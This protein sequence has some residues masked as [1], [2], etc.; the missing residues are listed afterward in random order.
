MKAVNEQLKPEIENPKRAHTS[1]RESEERYCSLVE[2][3]SKSLYLV[4]EE[5]N[6]LFMTKKHRQRLGLVSTRVEGTAYA[7]CHTKQET[8]AFR[9]KVKTVFETGRPL[10]YE[11]QSEQVG[12]YFVRTLSPV[13]DGET[14]KAVSVFSK[15]ITRQKQAEVEI[16]H[17]RFELA[18]LERLAAMGELTASLAHEIN[19]PLTTILS[20][21]QA[22]LRFIHGNPP[23]IDEVHATLQ[24]II[25]ADRRA[26]EI[27][28][29]LRAF[30][31]KGQLKKMPQAVNK[32]INDAIALV[33]GDVLL[34]KVSIEKSL[35]KQ[36]PRVEG[37]RVDLQ[38]VILNLI[39]NASDSMREIN[40]RPRRVV[41]STMRENAS[42][43]KIGI[44]DV[45]KGI[46]PDHL[47]AIF[48]PYFTTKK[49]GMGMGLAIC[50]SIID[51]HGGKIWAENNP[52][53][54]ATFYFTLPITE[55]D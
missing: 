23:D 42:F 51:A 50:R 44:R 33:K 6:Y 36:L 37:D 18:H 11:Y 13:M 26:S 3:T 15:N 17:N 14:V 10:S 12:N 19:Q 24:D 30:F 2:S 22:A 43:L 7:A 16:S 55:E 9:S 21:A 35:G 27:I 39:L 40:H 48:K 20:N 54:G 52:D 32:L 53:P 45:G 5:C 31:K 49:D 29:H 8:E 47:E 25:A 38:Q 46:D 4:D 34:K 41:I 28:R 1:L